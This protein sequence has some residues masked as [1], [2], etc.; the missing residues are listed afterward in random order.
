MSL[1]GPSIN[2]S[3]KFLTVPQCSDASAKGSIEAWKSLFSESAYL[4]DTDPGACTKVFS[5]NYL[6]VVK[7]DAADPYFIGIGSGTGEV[8]YNRQY[9]QSITLSISIDI[10]SGENT[11]TTSPIT[12]ENK[13]STLAWDP[14]YPQINAV[15]THTIDPLGSP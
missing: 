2:Y 5:I 14:G 7:S 10:N 1:T 6:T 13:C 4:S 9:V 12:V 3:N 15:L 8:L 11:L